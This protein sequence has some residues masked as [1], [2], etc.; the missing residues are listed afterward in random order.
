M[1]ILSVGMVGSFWVF[2]EYGQFTTELQELKDTYVD[3]Q[4][5]GIKQEVE[6][7][8]AY[9][10]F[11][12]QT[13]EQQ[14][15]DSIQSR[16]YEAVAVANNIYTTY[17]GEKS[18]QEIQEL[19]KETLRPWRFNNGRGY[20]FIYD[21]QGNNV[22]LP[23]SP[24]LEGQNLWN[25]QDSKGNY[26]IQI[27]TEMIREA[28]EGFQRWYWYKP[29]EYQ[30]MSEKIG[31]HKQFEPYGWW[32][33]TGEYVEDFE[34]DVQRE[35]LE[36]I[37]KIRF[38]EDGYIFAY[39]FNGVTL[40]HFKQ[41]NIGINQWN[42]K[43]ANG[44]YV[45]RKLISISQQE[46]GGFL[47][48]VGTVRPSTGL[49]SPKIGY[50]R[51]VKDWGWMV[52]AGVYV[53]SINKT[54]SLKRQNLIAK[55][56]KNILT[57]F[58]ILVASL[59]I[60]GVLLRYIY[61]K[62][63]KDLVIFNR[64][65]KQAATQSLH[66]SDDLVHFSEFKSLAH[67]ANQMVSERNRV[68]AS[69]ENLREQLIRSRKMEALGVLA[70]G[71]A[72]DLNN[73][74]SA[75]VGYPDLLLA[76]LPD[77]SPHRK[78]ILAI[79]DSGI[80]AASI[81]Q[82][83]LTLARRGVAQRITL[84]I[85]SIIENY[86]QSPEHQK[87]LSDNPGVDLTISL[88]PNLLMVKGSQV[89]LQK[90]IMNLVANAAE[91]Q[92][93]GGSIHIKTENRYIDFQAQK[94]AEPAEGEYIFLAIE[95]KGFGIAESDLE[96]IFEPFFS[97]KHPGKSGTGLGMAV[98]WG[99]VQDH[100]GYI[101][102]VTAENRG[103]TFELLFPATRKDEIEL[104]EA[105]EIANL[106]GNGESILVVDDLREQRELA[107]AILTELGY[108]VEVAVSGEAALE[109]LKHHQVDLLFMDMIMEPGIDGL[110]TFKRALLLHPN[111]KGIIA[112]GYTETDRVKAAISIGVGQYVKK[113]YTLDTI[114]KVV[115][116]ELNRV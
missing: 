75:V 19:I 64:F 104:G 101:N 12:R 36:W 105:D 90:T 62:T 60:I 14:L 65:F 91:A 76:N 80:K 114:G 11:K 69:L 45:L 13:T 54:I 51:S 9:I 63:T 43:D 40:A 49:P 86:L 31:F 84:N 110:E 38:G 109:Y 26:T 39:G 88:D 82:D 93:N 94:E 111:Q 4:K 35:T 24:S 46:G 92:P 77:D 96:H 108:T 103:T 68:S 29:G 113:P 89:H 52:G 23:F 50:A 10:D 71:V 21:M 22:L 33:G 42:F 58:L 61:R 95:D 87:I 106:S 30:K 41:E 74:L 27:A 78:S 17:R 2:Q 3:A 83:L 5:A 18:D 16:V 72:H 7:V 28:G 70:G 32:V 107:K 97:K 1:A 34:R 6:R 81:V 112:S 48:Y 53:D 20:F 85:N 59:L 102:I 98:V 66:I 116:E 25:L 79:K 56:Q 100:D 44:I 55:I 99:T 73:V 67:S 115:K 37:N 47:N 15:K 8:L 57:I